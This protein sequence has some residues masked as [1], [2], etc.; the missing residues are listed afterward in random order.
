[1]AA[2]AAVA[3]TAAE[4]RGDGAVLAELVRLADAAC[5]AIARVVVDASVASVRLDRLDVTG[6][7]RDAVAAHRLAGTDLAEEL[8]E[9]LV[10]AGDAVRLRQVLD[11]LVA[12][13][14]AHGGGRAV[15]VRAFGAERLVHVAVSDGGPGIPDEQ[16]PHIFELGV[17]AAD[18]PEGSGIGLALSRAIVEAHGGRLRVDWAPGSGATFVVTLPALV[19]QPATDASTS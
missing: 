12:N 16:Q 7:V 1:V 10:V 2:L 15:R 18:G 4:M 5:R 13:A 3:D 19:D 14:V 6:L 11:N 8:G 9:A 17:R